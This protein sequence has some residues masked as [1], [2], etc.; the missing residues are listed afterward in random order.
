MWV[1][2][3]FLAVPLIEIG[4]FVTVGGWLTLW[5]TLAIV[6]GT[7]FL[8]VTILRLQGLRAIA[9]MQT[10]LQSMQNPVSPMAHNAVIM[11]AGVLL[12]LPGFFTDTVGLLLLIRPLR[13]WV[14]N[15]LVGKMQD[16]SAAGR[17]Q[18][19]RSGPDARYNEEAIDAEYS[20]V[21]PERPSLRRDSKWTQD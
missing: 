21:E 3:L 5:P 16:Y 13:Q 10:A 19:W 9:D 2:V 17:A 11:A 4:L 20:E 14:I 1:F 8:G 7:G 15:R 6:I 12:I 18:D